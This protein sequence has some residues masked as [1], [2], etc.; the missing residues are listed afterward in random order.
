MTFWGGASVPQFV[1]VNAWVQKPSKKIG[2]LRRK[3][4]TDGVTSRRDVV[5]SR[6]DA[7]QLS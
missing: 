7:A 1:L 6:Y 2:G 4:P 5:F 3:S